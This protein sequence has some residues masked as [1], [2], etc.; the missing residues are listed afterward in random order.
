MLCDFCPICL[1]PMDVTPSCYRFAECPKGHYKE[2]GGNYH[3]DVIVN[4]QTFY[5]DDMG[6]EDPEQ[7]LKEAIDKARAEWV[8]S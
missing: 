6:F 7:E 4:D 5:F 2:S 3:L 8:D 1:G